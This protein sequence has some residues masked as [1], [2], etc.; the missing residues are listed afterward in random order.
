MI[1]QSD[2]SSFVELPDI[3]S[4]PFFESRLFFIDQEALSA[5]IADLL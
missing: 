5:V 2:F 3:D 1:F 4:C